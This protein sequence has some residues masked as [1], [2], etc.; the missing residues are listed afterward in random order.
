MRVSAVLSRL[1]A[2]L[3]RKAVSRWS[4][5]GVRHLVGLDLVRRYD[6][7]QW[8]RLWQLPEPLRPLDSALILKVQAETLE[9]ALN[10]K[11]T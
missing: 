11:T 5:P 4:V 2:K 9:L 3:A 8:Q 7:P 1:M 10:V 6:V